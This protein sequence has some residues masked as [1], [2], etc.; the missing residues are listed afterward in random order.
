MEER[1]EFV[2]LALKPRAN[3]SDLCRR[4]G[5]ERSNDYKW[6]KRTGLRVEGSWR[7]LTASVVQPIAQ[8]R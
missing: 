3:I 7:S 4:F 2:R 8:R 1:E 6:L 5:V